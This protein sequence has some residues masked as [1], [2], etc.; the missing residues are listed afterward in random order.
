MKITVSQLRRIIQEEV[1]REEGSVN[2]QQVEQ[3]IQE[4]LDEIAMR[5]NNSVVD[6]Y[7]SDYEGNLKLDVSDLVAQIAAA[8][9][10]YKG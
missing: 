4:K 8:I 7:K 9:S 5:L 1:S 10:G 6:N 2:R 3:M